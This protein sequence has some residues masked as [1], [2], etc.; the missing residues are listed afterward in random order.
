MKNKKVPNLLA[1]KYPMF[2]VTEKQLEILREC[3]LK[4]VEKEPTSGNF[5]LCLVIRDLRN[6]AHSD[7]QYFNTN[8]PHTDLMKRVTDSLNPGKPTGCYDVNRLDDFFSQLGPTT[9][10][11]AVQHMLRRIWLV[12]LIAYNEFNYSL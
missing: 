4:F 12:K 11:T 9:P 10:E 8:N 5:F 2:L 3:E 1:L 7:S 6:K